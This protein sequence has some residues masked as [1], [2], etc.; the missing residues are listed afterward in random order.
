MK[1]RPPTSDTVYDFIVVGAGS[2]GCPLAARLSESGKYRVLLL[3]AG[4]DDP[5]LWLKIP[6]GVGIVLLSE[7]SLWRFFTEPEPR[8]A[9]RTIFW[10][11]GRV[12][13]GTSSVNG[14]IWARGEPAEYDY[15]ARVISAEWSYAKSVATFKTVE[16]TN[17]GDSALRGRSGLVTVGEYTPRDPLSE[18][19]FAACVQA[20]IPATLDYNG[21]AYEGVGYLQ[22]NVRNGLRCGGREAYLRPAKKRKNLHVITG[23]YAERILFE[24]RR[25]HGVTY[26][27]GAE[28]RVVNARR[29][30]IICAGTIQSP[31][32]LELSGVGSGEHLRRLGIPIVADIASVGENCRDHLHTRVSYE[33]NA[34]ITLNDILT[35]PL[36]KLWTGAKYLWER[37]GPLSA[38]TATVHALARSSPSLRRPDVKIQLHHLS[39]ENPRHPA[40]LAVDPYPGFGIGT[41]PLRPES[42]GSIHIRSPDPLEPPS[43][44]ANYLGD[45]R[46]RASCIAALRLARKVAQA[47]ALRQLIRRETRPGPEVTSDDEL[48]GY[49]SEHGMTSYHPIGT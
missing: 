18:A 22:L 11:R 16:N 3:E 42:R 26:R 9:N 36:R 44:C 37:N 27:I 6:L 23:A 12:L 41:F 32:L 40:K 28:R 38:T 46:D 21:A 39:S 19:F 43:I 35:N 49:I 17:C 31:Q 10:P 25:A 45:E 13:G 7:R 29:E 24:Q 15:W 48:L 20:G 8:L 47:S 33:C 30:I 14:M 34:P 2:A 5:W 4:Y 1:N